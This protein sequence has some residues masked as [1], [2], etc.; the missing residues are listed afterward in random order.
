MKKG[1]NGHRKPDEKRVKGGW[2]KGRK[3][4]KADTENR[5]KKGKRW[6]VGR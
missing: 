4:R 6:M 3:E 2:L 1:E 5:M